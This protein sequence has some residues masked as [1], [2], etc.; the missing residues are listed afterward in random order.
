[1][2][3][4]LIY[5]DNAKLREGLCFLLDATDGF[6]VVGAF[7]NCMNVIEQCRSLKPD[8]VLMDI[9]MP[10]RDGIEGLKLIRT[11]DEEV[12]VIMLTVFDDNKNVFDAI[13]GGANG[14]I[15]KKT[16]P[17][18]LVEY[19]LDAEGGGAPMTSSIAAQVLKMFS[20]SPKATADYGLSE[21]E[22]EVL[23][24]LVNGHS[25]KMIASELFISLDT[26][27]SHI[28]KVYEKLHVNSKG[29]AINLALR[30]RIV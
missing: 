14:Y 16:P 13:R 10:E 12:K 21:R 24:L 19:L 22:R 2:V 9:N 20:G 11:T 5:E 30:N 25:Y 17:A 29:E 27:R 26:V 1:M 7:A 3:K 4:I 23:E 18:K 28:K 8:I 15:L 6:E